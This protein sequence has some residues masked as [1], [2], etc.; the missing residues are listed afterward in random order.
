[1]F[2]ETSILTKVTQYKVPEGIYNKRN[3]EELVC[4]PF[5]KMSVL[6]SYKNFTLYFTHTVQPVQEHSLVTYFKALS[7]HFPVRHS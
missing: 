1:M 7:S 4:Y 2:S 5:S 6:F 3:R